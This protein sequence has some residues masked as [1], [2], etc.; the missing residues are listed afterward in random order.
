VPGGTPASF[1]RT[2]RARLLS[3]IGL[4]RQG[5]EVERLRWDALS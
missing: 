1:D 5:D 2:C 4:V 3:T